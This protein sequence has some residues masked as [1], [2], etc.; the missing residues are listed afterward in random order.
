MNA[1][2]LHHAANPRTR[3]PSTKEDGEVIFSKAALELFSE[4]LQERL[5]RHR[6]LTEDEI[7][8]S[9]NYSLVER[10]NL[11]EFE[12]RMEFEHPSLPEKKLD[13]YV[14]ASD[15]HGAAAWEVKYDRK[16]P[17]G[18]NQPK[19]NKAGA[20]INDVFRLAGLSE[21]EQLER[22]LI[23]VTDE[24]MVGYFK[25][26]RNQFGSFFD[27]APGESFPFDSAW[28]ASLSASVK[29]WVKAPGKLCRVNAIYSAQLSANVALRVYAVVLESTT[30]TARE[31]GVE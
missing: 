31:P 22:V 20:L 3:I 8:N 19:S 27:L 25:N 16:P 6:T 4:L 30:R 7:E 9:L 10:G 5:K 17:G 15:S 21:D 29:K 2:A 1:V 24:E 12:I 18:M 23:Y 13:S 11:A 26:P 28:V 14:A